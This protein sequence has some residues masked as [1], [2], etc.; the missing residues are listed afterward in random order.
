MFKPVKQQGPIFR[1]CGTLVSLV[2][3]M[4]IV[5]ATLAFCLGVLKVAPNTV[6]TPLGGKWVDT[7]GKLINLARDNCHF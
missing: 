5:S 2:T 3:P 1:H 6:L 4:V 7:P